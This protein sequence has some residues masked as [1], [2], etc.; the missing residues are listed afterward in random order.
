M[1]TF[2]KQNPVDNVAEDEEAL[3]AAAVTKMVSVRKAA[4]EVEVTDLAA[5]VAIERL[6]TEKVAI[7]DQQVVT[8]QMVAIAKSRRC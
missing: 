6:V 4:V 2:F 8:V 5:A 1:H 3:A 7:A